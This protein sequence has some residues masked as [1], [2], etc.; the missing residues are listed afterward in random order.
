MRR[1]LP[2]HPLRLAGIAAGVVAVAAGTV[3][4]T[5]SA[6]GLNLSPRFGTVAQ[7][8]PSTGPSPLCT[9]F[10]NHL[11]SDLNTSP[12]N[13]NA[14]VQKAIGQTLDDQVK[15]GKL[16]QAR[17]DEIKKRLAGKAPCAIVGR[18]RQ[19]QHGTLAAYRSALITASASALGVAPDVLKAD[20]K[21]GMSL[22]QVAAAQNPPVTEAQFRTRLIAALAPV[23]DKAV[24]DGKLT[25]TRE[26]A[27]LQRLQTGTIPLWNRPA[28]RTATPS[29]SAST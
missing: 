20:L 9:S 27:I 26:A 16:T 15:A 14:A 12:A 21:K 28:P 10:V 2:L 5:A 8:D 4:I 18:L 6:A 7:A 24:A 19:A 3:W 25:K 22:S 11:S 1:L 29:A 17:A 23:L 13:L